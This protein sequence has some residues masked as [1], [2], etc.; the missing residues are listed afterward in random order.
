MKHKDSVF[1]AGHQKLNCLPGNGFAST[2]KVAAKGVHGLRNPDPQTLNCAL[3]TIAF[4]VSS[5]RDGP[6]PSRQPNPQTP[7]SRPG[8]SSGFEHTRAPAR[9]RLSWPMPTASM[10]RLVGWCLGESYA[11]LL[12]MCSSGFSICT[13]SSSSSSRWQKWLCWQ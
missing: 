2:L 9:N 12:P 1:S 8:T 3:H 6:P 4:L 13:C 7:N 5:P 11:L 10:A